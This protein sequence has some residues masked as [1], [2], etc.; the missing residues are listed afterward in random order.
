VERPRNQ[1][2]RQKIAVS[3]EQKDGELALMIE[4]FGSELLQ[5]L[6][7]SSPLFFALPQGTLDA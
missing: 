5:A 6:L 7:E 1:R 4:A 3:L 2:R